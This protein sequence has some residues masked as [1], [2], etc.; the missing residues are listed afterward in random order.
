MDKEEAV[1]RL[2][3]LLEDECDCPECIENKEAYRFILEYMIELEADLYSANSII[4]EQIDLLKD[5]TPNQVI[6]DKV[7]ELE[8][9]IEEF[10][11]NTFSRGL[12]EIE[13]DFW[14]S[15]LNRAIG[16]RNILQ[17]ILNKGEVKNVKNVFN[18]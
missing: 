16:K 2:K 15:E 7:D 9:Q 4:D 13:F 18:E 10:K 8:E 14:R 5:S 11:K 6:L 12:D 1:K 17:E 3:I